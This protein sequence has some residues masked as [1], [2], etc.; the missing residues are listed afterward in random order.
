MQTKYD[1]IGIGYNRTRKADKYLVG[2]FYHHLNP[3]KGKQYLDIGCGTGNYTIALNNQGVYFTGIDPSNEMLNIARSKSEGIEW[4]KGN[5]EA[6]PLGNYLFD[7]AIASLTIHHWDDLNAGFTELSRV[8]KPKSSL[9]IFTSTPKQMESYWLMHYFPKMLRTSILQ[10]PSQETV[11]KSLMNAGF[12]I[13]GTEKYFVN[14]ELEDLFLQ[15]GKYN[16][17]LYLK[18]EVR[19]G[20]SSFASFSNQEEVEKGLQELKKDIET[21]K[22]NEIIEKYESDQGDYLF[23]ISERK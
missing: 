1:K 4:I 22:I 12:E 7:G 13:I 8:L 15:S 16:P 14:N 5:V 6:I 17:E 11:E 10:M 21:G 2:R 3:E 19:Q 23:I 18:E 9:V 20:I